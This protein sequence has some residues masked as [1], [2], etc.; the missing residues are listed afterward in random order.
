MKTIKKD[1]INYEKRNWYSRR[2]DRQ[3]KKYCEKHGREKFLKLAA[4][5]F[6]RILFIAICIPIQATLNLLFGLCYINSSDTFFFAF[7]IFI[8]SSSGFFF[9]IEIQLIAI[10]P[11]HK[12]RS[13]RCKEELLKIEHANKKRKR[14]MLSFFI[15]SVWWR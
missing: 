7:G 5:D 10:L 11:F 15:L 3:D 14:L 4:K 6:L 8:L 12:R 2:S 9:L 13:N 1:N